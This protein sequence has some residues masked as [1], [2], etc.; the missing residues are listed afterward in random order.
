MA[1]AIMIQGTTSNAGKSLLTAGLCRI[2]KED[3]YKV[4]PFKSQNMAL[5]SFITKDGLEMGR[6]QAVQAEACGILPDVR[7]NP[8]LLKPTSDKGSQVILHGEVRGTMLAKEYFATKQDLIPEIEKAYNSLAKE[9]DII[10]IEG[11][12]SPC[13]IN[14]KENDIVNMGMAKIAKAPVLIAG[15][16]ERG[17][18]FAALAGT[19]LLL[20]DDE[21]EMVKGV[22][23]NK[24]RGDVSL[25][26]P[27]LEML[28]NI[29]KV[30]TIGVIPYLNVEIDDEDSLSGRLSDK[31]EEKIIDIAVI[32]L[33]R[34]SNF[35][36]F[37]PFGYIEGV[38]VRYIKSVRE[39]GN[40][41]LVI[42]PGTKNTMSDLLWLRETGLEAT[43][44]KYS[45]EGNPIF[46]ICG[47]YQMLGK[48]LSD[49]DN[50][51]HGGEMLG[52]GILDYSTV[53]EPKKIRTQ[54]TGK[55]SNVSGIF[56]RLSKEE[57]SAYEIH[58]G[59][60]NTEENIVNKGNVYGTYFHGVFDKENISKII[61]E[62][63]LKKKGLDFSDLKTFDNDEFKESQYVILARE[64][65]KSL[66]MDAI[67]KILE[68]GI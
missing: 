58:M 48:K 45:N 44:L 43:I 41:D 34:I 38:G 33:P 6:A 53:F 67:Y 20:D 19:M 64:L 36:D 60:T 15:D 11:A 62:E 51:E 61:I 4:A 40:P 57:Y 12:G 52:L 31:K 9:F 66:D 17:G 65:R 16:I 26:E 68:E 42:I 49:P 27:G 25:L 39:F 23:I 30:P 22:L 37:N 3:G 63:L 21:K 29:I 32:G 5:N 47:G 18:V 59:I 7:M 1:K 55:L 50:I 56:E 13:E 46:G 35:T 24:F 8:I 2:F 28:E 14:L 10:V 54:L